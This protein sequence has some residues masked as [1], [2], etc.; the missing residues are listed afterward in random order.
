M[1][2]L[3]VDRAVSARELRAEMRD[4]RRGRA[5]RSFGEAFGDA[6]VMIVA[7]L[8]IGAM[9]FSALNTV[10]EI[11]DVACTQSCTQVRSAVP[12]V[13]VLAVTGLALAAAR[14]L[15]PVFSPPAAAHWLLTSPVPRADWLWPALLRAVITALVAGSL[16][17]IGPILV[18]AADLPSGAALMTLG[19]LST[20]AAV[21][22]AGVAQIHEQA[23]TRHLSTTLALGTWGLLVVAALAPDQLPTGTLSPTVLLGGVLVAALATVA[24]IVMAARA[25]PHASQA[26]LAPTAQAWPSLSGALASFDLTLLFDVLQSR[27]WAAVA[28]VRSRRGGPSGWWALVHT[29]VRRVARNPRPWLVLLAVGIVPFALV[30]AGVE[31][32][33]AI[34]TALVGLLV[35]PSLASGLRV[36]VRT[37]T[38]ARIYPFST[39][40]VR[41][42]HLL[43]PTVGLLALGL[44]TGVALAPLLPLDRALLMGLATGFSALAATTRWVASAPPDYAAPLLSTPAGGL[45]PGMLGGLFKGLDVWLLTSLPL[46]LGPPWWIGSILV[47]VGV[48]GFKLSK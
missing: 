12:W 48:I 18:G 14:L 7:V 9:A 20:V 19:V 23:W 24:G 28:W 39:R 17:L 3:D 32:G 10:R 29:E 46:L 47:S 4:W 40:E 35:G 43:L 25:L 45:P 5:D 13:A 41:S 26:A 34:G 11:T 44:V 15:G 6:Y 16:L 38:L 2:D 8:L 36:V 21:A 42:A 30:R 1:S 31:Q 22:W 37:P 33:T 27:R